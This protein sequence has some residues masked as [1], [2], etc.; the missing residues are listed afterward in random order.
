M[1][2]AHNYPHTG[3]KNFE[4][5]ACNN[6]N[7]KE[8]YIEFH[9][10]K[11]L[12][13]EKVCSLICISGGCIVRKTI[14]YILAIVWGI[15]LFFVDKDE[16]QVNN[17]GCDIVHG[18]CINIPGSYHCTCQQGYELQENSEFICEGMSKK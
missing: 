14:T 17:G 15:L 5:D 18:V 16:C 11:S 4:S 3:N 13:K 12:D 1:M 6:I 10:V 9:V 7:G 2:F 8:I